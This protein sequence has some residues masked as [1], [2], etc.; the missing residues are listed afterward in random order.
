VIEGVE[1]GETVRATDAAVAMEGTVVATA[2]ATWKPDSM[3]SG[4]SGLV[5]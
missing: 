1:T 4:S 5:D 3:K 2:A